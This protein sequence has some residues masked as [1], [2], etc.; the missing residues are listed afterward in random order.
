MQKKGASRSNFKIQQKRG[1]GPEWTNIYHKHI[2]LKFK[3][4]L[5]PLMLLT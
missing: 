2:M 1:L 3:A 4:K 5:L